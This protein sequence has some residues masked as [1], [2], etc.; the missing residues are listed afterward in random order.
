MGAPTDQSGQRVGGSLISREN[1][2]VTAAPQNFCAHSDFHF[3]MLFS[4]A[5]LAVSLGF[6]P[7]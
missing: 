5:I 6:A 4:P 3:L 1:G 7:D 2:L